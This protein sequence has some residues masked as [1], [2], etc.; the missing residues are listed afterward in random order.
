MCLPRPH[1]ILF[2]KPKGSLQ[3]KASS[4]LKTRTQVS[5]FF[6][7][8]LLFSVASHGRAAVW[9]GQ[10]MG[11]GGGGRGH[12]MQDWNL[13]PLYVTAAGPLGA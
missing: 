9:L 4:R 8:K 3:N 11:L 6:R 1:P 7:G 10:I 5:R 13:D 2:H 12:E